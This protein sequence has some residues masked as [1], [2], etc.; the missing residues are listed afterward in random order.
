MAGEQELW[1]QLSRRDVEAFE[2]FY[3]QNFS[4]IRSFVRAFVGSSQVADDIA[5]ETFF[6]L[7]SIRMALTLRDRA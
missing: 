7:W 4:R 3:R 5:Q 1:D 6:Q 2:C